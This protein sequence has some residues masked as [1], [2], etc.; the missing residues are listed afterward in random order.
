M[1][2]LEPSGKVSA[3]PTQLCPPG[4]ARSKMSKRQ[5]STCQQRTAQGPSTRRWRASKASRCLGSSPHPLCHVTN[6]TVTNQ[7]N[8]TRNVCHAGGNKVS[9][10]LSLPW[11]KQRVSFKARSWLSPV[12]RRATCTVQHIPSAQL[13]PLP[14]APPTFRANCPKRMAVNGSRLVVVTNWPMNRAM[15]DPFATYCIQLQLEKL[16]LSDI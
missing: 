16:L 13:A 11:S 8:R 4:Y 15:M 5:V 1:D 7:T 14:I 2:T 9:L 12:C 3:T 10:Q 6:F